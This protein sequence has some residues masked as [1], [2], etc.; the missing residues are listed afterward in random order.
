MPFLT[1]CPGPRDK[2]ARVSL[3]CFVNYS[4]SHLS[5]YCLFSLC[6]SHS[7]PERDD[8]ISVVEASYPIGSVLSRDGNG[9]F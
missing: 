9:G 8:I 6:L 4:D 2:G 7:P 3:G 5:I 1:V